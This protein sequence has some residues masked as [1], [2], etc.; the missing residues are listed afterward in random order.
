MFT[1]SSGVRTLLAIVAATLTLTPQ[2]SAAVQHGPF[3]T[4]IATAEVFGVRLGMTPDEAIA[5]AAQHNIHITTAQLGFGPC[6]NQRE[7][8]IHAGRLVAGQT[9]VGLSESPERKF[10][11]TIETSS[12]SNTIQ[13]VFAEDWPAN[14]GKMLLLSIN[15]QVMTPTLADK[16]KFIEATIAKFGKPTLFSK[17]GSFYQ[18]SIVEPAPPTET[19]PN[20]ALLWVTAPC[21]GGIAPFDGCN[22]TPNAMIWSAQD[23]SSYKSAPGL[24]VLL[25]F[26]LTNSAQL[27]VCNVAEFNHLHNLRTQHE[28]SLTSNNVKY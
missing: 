14:P 24:Y 9:F 25:H 4:A 10:L 8:L 19:M 13:M 18:Q 2:A 26:P 6:E 20:P 11:Q 21:W 28:N 3:S 12:G 23:L 5:A 16:Q 17:T 7:A 1:N 27:D 15:A 22:A